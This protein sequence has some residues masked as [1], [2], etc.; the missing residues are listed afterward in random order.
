MPNHRNQDG[1]DYCPRGM[2]P[3]VKITLT[4]EEQLQFWKKLNET[5]NLQQFEIENI[6]Y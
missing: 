2:P 1:Y 5:N 6:Y 3:K 4:S